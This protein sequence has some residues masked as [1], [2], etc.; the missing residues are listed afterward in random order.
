MVCAGV[1]GTRRLGKR[2]GRRS[3]TGWARLRR[4][5]SAT[6]AI[7]PFVKPRLLM[8]VALAVRGLGFK[9]VKIKCSDL[10]ADLR[11]LSI[12]R[13]ILG[14][15]SDLRVDA[16]CAWTVDEALH[17]IERMARTASARSNTGGRP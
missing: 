4:A 6:T 7:V 14:P 10:D 16:N 17:A 9:Q 11:A 1:G 12:L 3:S 15:A 8:L 2:F 13:R 5:K